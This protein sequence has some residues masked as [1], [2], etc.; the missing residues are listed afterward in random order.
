MTALTK[1]DQADLAECEEIIDRALRSFDEFGRALRD[2]RDKRLYRAVYSSFEDYCQA[3]W[4]MKSSRARQLIAAA[5]VHED[6]ADV[7]PALPQS[8][9][10]T[11]PLASLPTEERQEVWSHVVATAGPAPTGEAVKAAV[12][13]LADLRN[14]VETQGGVWYTS[15][16]GQHRVDMPGRPFKAYTT[17]ELRE[18]LGMQTVVVEPEPAQLPTTIYEVVEQMAAQ[19]EAPLKERASPLAGQAANK[20]SQPAT[21]RSVFAQQLIE[22]ARALG[23]EV[24]PYGDNGFRYTKNGEPL[25][26]VGSCYQLF[27]DVETWQAQADSPAV[28]TVT[29]VTVAP[30]MSRVQKIRAHLTPALEGLDALTLRII[31]AAM[32]PDTALSLPLSGSH[33]QVANDVIGAIERFIEFPKVGDWWE[34]EK[35]EL[36]HALLDMQEQP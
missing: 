9:A 6:L 34:P 28:A 22:R 7:A 12:S 18:A 19:I 23:Y 20:Q 32:I 4:N 31:A 11:R 13:E 27:A 21:N 29:D 5:I 24:K 10:Q 1:H 8:E 16:D 35:T 25:G 26:V 30:S 36:L 33:E 2:I 17:E 15:R 14:A 3:R